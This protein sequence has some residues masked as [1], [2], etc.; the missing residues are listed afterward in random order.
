MAKQKTSPDEKLSHQDFDLFQALKE[1]DGQNYQW[2]GQLKIEQ[3]Q[4]FFPY[5]LIHWL[6]SVG[7][8]G[9]L[10]NWYVLSTNERANLHLF[11]E[12][13]QNHPELQWLM[14]AS[15]SPGQG[16]QHHTWI[17]HLKSKYGRLQ[18]SA[19]KREVSEYF[20]KVYPSADRSMISEISDTYVTEQRHRHRL[21]KMYPNMKLEDINLLSEVI[22]SQDIDDYEKQ[23]GL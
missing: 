3:Q 11:N 13:I 5:M 21:S 17:P 4:K 19:Q 2:F 14:L 6:S 15:V 23:C 12:R 10:C 16:K 7:R 1:L 22:T 20:Q 18:E 8:N 9:L